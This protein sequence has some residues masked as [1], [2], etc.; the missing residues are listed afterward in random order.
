[1]SSEDVLKWYLKVVEVLDKKETFFKLVNRLDLVDHIVDK[2]LK[3][4][5]K[6]RLKIFKKAR[7]IY[8]DKE[9]DDDASD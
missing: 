5:E 6:D 3:L 2:Q 8:Y 1:M 9:G 7:T 4:A